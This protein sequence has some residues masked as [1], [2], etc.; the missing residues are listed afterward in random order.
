MNQTI[1]KVEKISRYK[2]HV[3]PSEMTTKKRG[4]FV[5]Y[6]WMVITCQTAFSA[7]PTHTVVKLHC[8]ALFCHIPSGPGASRHTLNISETAK[9]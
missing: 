2:V 6:M 5:P 4:F 7:G 3:L 8:S 9:S 1:K